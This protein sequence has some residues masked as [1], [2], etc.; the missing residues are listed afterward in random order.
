MGISYCGAVFIYAFEKPII[1]PS[2]KTA[3]G[4]RQQDRCQLTEGLGQLAKKGK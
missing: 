1:R 2:K 3:L 4:Q